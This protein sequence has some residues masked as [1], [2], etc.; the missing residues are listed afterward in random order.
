MVCGAS[1][2]KKGQALLYRSEDMLQW[3]FVNVLG[4]KQRRMGE[5]VGM[6]GFLRNRPKDMC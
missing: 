6:P 5:H 2:D 3:S 1:K 4:R